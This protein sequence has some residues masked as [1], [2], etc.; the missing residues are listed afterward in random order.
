[1]QKLIK[2]VKWKKKR[3]IKLEAVSRHNI[4]R[5]PNL[6]PAKKPSFYLI[7]DLEAIVECC[8]RNKRTCFIHLKDRNPFTKHPSVLARRKNTKFWTPIVLCKNTEILEITTKSGFLLRA[9]KDSKIYWEVVCQ[10][11][12]ISLTLN[13]FHFLHSNDWLLVLSL[14]S[15]V[16]PVPGCLQWFSLISPPRHWRWSGERHIHLSGSD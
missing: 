2:S 15:N 13:P 7:Y 11:E 6:V 12:V 10:I 3:I 14:P 9:H 16:R 8:S 1:M 5:S 4:N